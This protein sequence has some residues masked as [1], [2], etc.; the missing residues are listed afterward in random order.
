MTHGSVRRATLSASLPILEA[1]RKQR[2]AVNSTL[3]RDSHIPDSALE[4]LPTEQVARL[5]GLSESWFAHARLRGEGPKFTRIGTR[6]F[7]SRAALLE[8][9]RSLTV[10]PPPRSIPRRRS[11]RGAQP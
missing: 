4:L 2:N 5:T 3:Q 1:M 11:V 6:V 7:Y 8:W 10:E 9:S